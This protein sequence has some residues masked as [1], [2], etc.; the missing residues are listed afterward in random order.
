MTLI[1]VAAVVTV[2]VCFWLFL[3]FADALVTPLDATPCHTT[4]C[5]APA[6]TPVRS[7]DATGEKCR[8]CAE[9]GEAYGWWTVQRR[10]ALR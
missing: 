7:G 6:T 3:R 9:E 4:G 1:E 2:P 5:R 10:E 8:D